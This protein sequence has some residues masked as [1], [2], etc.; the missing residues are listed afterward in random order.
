MKRVFRGLAY[1]LGGLVAVFV[2]LPVAAYL[3]YFSP[4]GPWHSI[5]VPLPENL[6]TITFSRIGTHPF[7]AEYDR[8]V[9]I[10]LSDGR[11][12][13]SELMTN[14]GGQTK[15]FFHSQPAHGGLGPF[16][17]LEDRIGATWINLNHLCLKSSQNPDIATDRSDRC[18][19]ELVPNSLEWNY[20]GRVEDGEDE[21]EFIAGNHWPPK[22]VKV[23]WYLGPPIPLP[24]KGWTFEAL[25]RHPA[26][27]GLP[28]G[29]KWL[30]L[31]EAG[32]PPLTVPIESDNP[33]GDKASLRWYPAF[34]KRGPY[35][36]VGIN[37]G[38]LI[39]LRRRRIFMIHSAKTY[40][41]FSDTPNYGTAMGTLPFPH[42]DG[43][44]VVYL[45]KIDR[46]IL[47]NRNGIRRPLPSAPDF[48]SRI[49]PVELGALHWRFSN[50]K[51][52]PAKR[53]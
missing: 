47:K 2:G 52:T 1:V 34:A 19:E 42:V 16:L 28:G 38:T 43:S 46:L 3:I 50:L 17:M 8:H 45:E 27:W 31:R 40:G 21:L 48:F 24:A 53:P 13:R 6:G 23:D 12:L 14:Y 29:N 5:D 39:D 32:K 44:H 4:L 7:F 25:K 51:Y 9:D 36:R 37:A 35:L 26:R 49:Q 41:F 33:A 20:F 30:I 22:G 18:A 11:R 15:M 10:R